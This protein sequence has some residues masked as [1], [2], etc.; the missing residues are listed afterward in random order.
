MSNVIF[1]PFLHNQSLQIVIGLYGQIVKISL[2]SLKCLFLEDER[3]MLS[4]FILITCTSLKRFY[5]L[6]NAVQEDP[7]ISGDNFLSSVINR[8]FSQWSTEVIVK[9]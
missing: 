5:R 2:V 6:D 8:L 7:K 4:Q 9:R 3:D 1:I